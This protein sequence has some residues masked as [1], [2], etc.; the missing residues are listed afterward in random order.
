M[1]SAGTIS[2]SVGYFSI[3]FIAGVL[4]CFLWLLFYLK[5]DRHPEPKKE[6][7]A[8]FTI[9]ALMTAPA[10]AMEV[11]L[12]N[13]IDSF[14]LGTIATVIISNIIAVA[15]IEEFAKYS[16]VWLKEQAVNQNHYLDEPVDFV[17]YMIVSALGFAAVENLLFLLPVVQEQMAGN[18]MPLQVDGAFYLI[19]LSLFRSLS[20]IL[21]HTLCSGV[22][23][24]YMAM[25]FCHREKKMLL[26][27]TGFLTVSCLHGLYNFSIMKSGSDAAYLFIPLAII[28]MLAFTLYLQFQKL[29]KMKSVCDMSNKMSKLK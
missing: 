6:I 28:T 5:R 1:A 17:I 16:A 8:V 9:G 12:I 24:Y 4:P 11:F 3:Y 23:G 26:L 29:L 10:V 20:A 7:L 2:N 15:F 14:T 18:A 27:A 21:L 22:I 25:T 19:S 13:V